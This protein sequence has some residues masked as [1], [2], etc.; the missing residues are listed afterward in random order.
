[1]EQLSIASPAPQL[2]GPLKSL[3]HYSC[4]LCYR[5]KVKC[6]KKNP[7]TYCVKHQAPCIPASTGASHPRKKRFPEAEL[8]RRLRKYEA[9][10]TAY[11]ADI[12]AILNDEEP[13]DN[14]QY[15]L[16]S[17]YTSSPHTEQTEAAP[18]R[19]EDKHDL[20]WKCDHKEVSD[21]KLF[22]CTSY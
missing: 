2:Q 17:V 12:D 7:C 14:M 5:R 8:L 20:H 1:M 21:E 16:E 18:S 6:D 10:L 3:N 4:D 11:G 9:A 13:T 15:G 19:H 22:S